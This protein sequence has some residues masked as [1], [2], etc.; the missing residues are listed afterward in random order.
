MAEM[1]QPALPFQP[2]HEFDVFH[3]WHRLETL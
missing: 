1:F 3:E 2:P